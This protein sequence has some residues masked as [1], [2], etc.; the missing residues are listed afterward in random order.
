VEVSVRQYRAVHGQTILGLRAEP[1]GFHWAIVTGTLRQAVLEGSGSEAA[2]ETFS[3]AESLAWVRQKAAYI[4]DIYKPT[5]VAVRYPERVARGFNKDSAKSR[6][7]VEGVLVEVSGTKNRT[8]VTGA[9]NTF[10]KHLGSKFP[11]DDLSSDELRGLDWSQHK[12]K[13]REAILVAVSL[14]PSE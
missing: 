10:G 2:P 6:C 8:V 1:K 7:R 12:D 5:A 9:L 14:L 3:E 4:I 13:V 11:K